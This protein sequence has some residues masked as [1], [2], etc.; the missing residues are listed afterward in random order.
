MEWNFSIFCRTCG[1]D[2]GLYI[3]SSLTQGCRLQS[4]PFLG[5]RKWIDV[6][7]GYVVIAAMFL[8][9]CDTEHFP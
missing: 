7:M 1:D 8:A 5:S 9:L 4:E 6:K 2:S 3:T